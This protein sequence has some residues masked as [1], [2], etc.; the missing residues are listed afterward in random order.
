MNTVTARDWLEFHGMDRSELLFAATRYRQA[1]RDARRWWLRVV[2]RNRAI[3]AAAGLALL[4]AWYV[5]VT[6]SG[7]PVWLA[8]AWA[9]VLAA[10]IWRWHS[11][12]RWYAQLSADERAARGARDSARS[13][14]QDILTRLRTA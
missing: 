4:G 8:V 2:A 11:P 14:L 7:P 13:A 9:W 3:A 5:P 12:R 6:L 10:T 1:S